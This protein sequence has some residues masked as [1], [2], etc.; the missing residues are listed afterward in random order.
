MSDEQSIAW[1]QEEFEKLQK[2]CAKLRIENSLKDQSIQKLTSEL[3]ALQS[4]CDPDVNA[5]SKLNEVASRRAKA[6]EKYRI[7]YENRVGVTSLADCSHFDE[8]GFDEI[9]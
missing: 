5:Q 7:E 1:Y 6:L 2:T 3:K 8:V 4:S 9:D